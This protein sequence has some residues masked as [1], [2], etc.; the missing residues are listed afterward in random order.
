MQN[1]RCK[2]QEIGVRSLELEALHQKLGTRSQGTRSQK[3][4]TRNQEAR[5]QKLRTRSLELEAGTRSKKLGT[6][7]QRTRSQKLEDQKL[8]ARDQELGSFELEAQNQKLRTRSLEPEAQNQKLR[9][10][11]WNRSQGL[12]QKLEAWNQKLEPE[13]KGQDSCQNCYIRL[14]SIFLF[15]RFSFPSKF[16]GIL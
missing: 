5:N 3:L 12:V 7:S 4:G 14:I 6:R 9:T 2:P 11:S 10:R 15:R 8:E 13:V 16:R 1:F